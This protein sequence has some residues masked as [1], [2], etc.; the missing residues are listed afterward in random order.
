MTV[1][2]PTDDDLVSLPEDAD[3]DE[4]FWRSYAVHVLG[5]RASW[6]DE[7][8]SDQGVAGL[9]EELGGQVPTA[10]G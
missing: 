10:D 6:V 8:V 9:V 1:P 4:E 5:A 2:P 3:L 7:L